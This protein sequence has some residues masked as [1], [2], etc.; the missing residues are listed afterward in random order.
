MQ[1]RSHLVSQTDLRLLTEIMNNTTNKRQPPQSP[2]TLAVGG[3]TSNELPSMKLFK[4]M[5]ALRS[6]KT[7][8]EQQ[9]DQL[10]AEHEEARSEI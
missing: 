4:R 7:E 10:K 9:M 3:T 2:S 1:H 8:L 5:T 6:E